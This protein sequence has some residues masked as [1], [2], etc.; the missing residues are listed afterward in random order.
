[1]DEDKE[2]RMRLQQIT[3]CALEQF[4][5]LQNSSQSVRSRSNREAHPKAV[6]STKQKLE[7]P[8]SSDSAAA[9]GAS[10]RLSSQVV[11]SP[12]CI[13]SRQHSTPVDLPSPTR[14]ESMATAAADET[15]STSNRPA[16]LQLYNREMSNFSRSS[17]S[18]SQATPCPPPLSSSPNDGRQLVSSYP[19]G[20]EQ[21]RQ[22]S[23]EEE[24]CRVCSQPKG[25]C[26]VS[27]WGE[28]TG[29]GGG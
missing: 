13:V 29:G 27:V 25:R 11:S 1:M 2:S 23:W 20:P 14:T 15:S 3:A 7:E 26:L 4:T 6:L 12:R 28:G 22:L 19:P 16:T 17:S 24:R 21:C 10:P 8:S 9:A 5:L 18:N